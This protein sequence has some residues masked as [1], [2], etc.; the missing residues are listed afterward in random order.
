MDNSDAITA[1]ELVEYL[2]HVPPDERPPSLRHLNAFKKR[3]VEAQFKM[4]DASGDGHLDFEEF[5]TWWRTDV[6][7]DTA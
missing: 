2:T 3:Q 6:W 5:Q 4:I 1:D 7:H